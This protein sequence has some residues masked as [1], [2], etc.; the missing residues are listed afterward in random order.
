MRA[1][2]AAVAVLAAAMAVLPAR[3][4]GA[5]VPPHGPLIFSD[6]FTSLHTAR[7]VT[8]VGAQ[9]QRWNN[10]G[11]LPP[12]Y[13]GF[14]QP[15]ATGAALYNPRQLATGA[16]LVIRAKRN[17]GNFAAQYAWQSSTINTMGKISLPASGWFAT[18][19]AKMPDTSHGMWPSIWFMPDTPSS[20]VPELDGFEGGFREL[21]GVPANRTAHYDY[22]APGGQRASEQDAGTDLSAGWH[23]YAVRYLPGR[24]ITWYFDGRAVFKV[25]QAQATIVRGTYEMMINMQVAAPSTSWWHTVPAAG[26]GD[27]GGLRVASV[28]VYR[29]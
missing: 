25:T 19:Y 10:F 1:R 12:P 2:I 4:A 20:P 5:S 11:E 26:S 23:H 17:H 9:G 3:P 6:T 15:G 18:V 24:S 13:S 28:H 7:W 27:G 14:N 22:F 16:G 8:Y 29:P 21:P